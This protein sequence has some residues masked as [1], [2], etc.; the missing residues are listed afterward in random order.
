MPAIKLFRLKASSAVGA[1]YLAAK[2]AD[3]LLPIDF[4]ANAEIF[5]QTSL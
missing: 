5:F 4:D 1:A 3:V 2:K